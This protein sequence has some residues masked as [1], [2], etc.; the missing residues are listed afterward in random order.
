ML[1]G[2][3]LDA[4]PSFA[5]GQLCSV[6][7]PGNPAPFAVREHGRVCLQAMLVSVGRSRC[8]YC[9]LMLHA[10]PSDII[11]LRWQRRQPSRAGRACC[12]QIGRALLSADEARAARQGR[13][14]GLWHAFGDCLWALAPGRAMPNPG[15]DVAAG[16][17]T[18][19]EVCSCEMRLG[20]CGVPLGNRTIRCCAAAMHCHRRMRVVLQ[21][22]AASQGLRQRLWTQAAHRSSRST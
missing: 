9:W 19:A 22:M 13:L 16:R 4:L 14:L 20:R 6:S 3:N 11:S 7:V 15:F 8:V 18:A 1:P 5:R 2:V 12:L 17:V 10:C 21:P